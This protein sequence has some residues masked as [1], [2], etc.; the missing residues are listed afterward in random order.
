MLGRLR[1]LVVHNNVAKAIHIQRGCISSRGVHRWHPTRPCSTQ[2]EEAPKL[3][4]TGQGASVPA[5]PSD[6]L[7]RWPGI[8]SPQALLRTFDWAGTVS[9]AASGCLTAGHM[10]L[11]SLGCAVVGSITALGGGTV[12]DCMLNQRVF[13]MDEYEYILLCL[14]TCAA[15]L[16]A[17]KALE[18]EDIVKEDASWFWWSDTLGIG[19]FCCIGAQNAIRLNLHPV[20]CILCGMFTSTFGGVTRDVLT[21]RDVRILHSKSEIYASTALGGSTMYM[22]AK[23]F[24]ASPA[25][26]IFSGASTAVAMRYAAAHHDLKL[27]NA[28][29]KEEVWDD[30]H[31]SKEGHRD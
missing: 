10:G 7:T 14:A 29:W 23:A 16:A 3:V 8:S 24:G 12:R 9:F 1:P 13:W 20:I 27:P 11:D 19:A 4:K 26:K 17:W 15:T 31:T 25:I 6:G 30:T 22:I 18:D 2:A 21:R 28:A 5:L